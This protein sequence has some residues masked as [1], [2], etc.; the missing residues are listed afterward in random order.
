MNKILLAT[1]CALSVG[2]YAQGLVTFDNYKTT[3]G[4]DARVTIGEGGPF[5]G[6]TY[7]GQLFAGADAGSLTA[8]GAPVLFRNAAA[9]GGS[10]RIVGAGAVTTPVASGKEAFVQMRAWEVAKG[11]SWQ[12]AWTKTTIG[13]GMSDVIKIKVD[14]GSDNPTGFPGDLLGLKAFAINI[15][16]PSTMALGVLGAAALL[17]RRRS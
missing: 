7:Y 2:A 9:G 5:V 15:P 17:L 1:A 3:L 14:G 6:N 10:G 12:G 4:I 8:V 11:N 13:T 16:E